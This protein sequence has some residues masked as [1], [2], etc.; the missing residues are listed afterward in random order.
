[1]DRKTGRVDWIRKIDG[2][3]E[4]IHVCSHGMLAVSVE[5]NS[6]RGT[7]LLS[8]LNGSLIKQYDEA[9]IQSLG[10]YIVMDR[11]IID[12]R[13]WCEVLSLENG[14]RFGAIGADKMII[15]KEIRDEYGSM[16]EGRCIITVYK[17]RGETLVKPCL[18]RIHLSPG[19][20]EWLE[21]SV[22]EKGFVCHRMVNVTVKTMTPIEVDKISFEKGILKIRIKAN[23]FA[24]RA[25]KTLTV[26]FS[27][28]EVNGT[29][30][31]RSITVNVIV[32][33]D[34][35]FAYYTLLLDLGIIVAIVIV[36]KKQTF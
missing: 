34:T 10:N 26:T 29:H 14:F 23:A 13:S 22:L 27:F 8:S 28:S 19:E 31:I 15:V 4:D 18:D 1:M 33:E 16:W 32:S 30:I 20:T 25:D 5:S 6:G 12:L 36:R 9:C 21:V 3:V 7:Y 2:K 35:L 24:I 11:H 17:L